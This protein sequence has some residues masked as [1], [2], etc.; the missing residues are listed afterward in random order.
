MPLIK[1][2]M[3]EKEITLI[4]KAAGRL[5]DRIH[6]AA[7]SISAAWARND[8]EHA[9]RTGSNQ[10]SYRDEAARLLNMLQDASPYHSD[11]FSKWVAGMF[12]SVLIWNKDEGEW[13]ANQDQEVTF[14]PDM[15]QVVRDTPFYKY[16]P[17][18]K[19]SPYDDMEAFEKWLQAARSKAAKPKEG[20]TF[21]EGFVAHMGKALADYKAKQAA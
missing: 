17:P 18:K 21:H 6:I 13:V 9:Q 8:S 10:P 15:L 1:P 2:E 20:Y 4:S 19:A 3:I 7:V 11:S 5:Q 12:S 14:T 16:S